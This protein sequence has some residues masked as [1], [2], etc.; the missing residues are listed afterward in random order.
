MLREMDTIITYFTVIMTM[1]RMI[2]MLYL[3]YINQPINTVSGLNHEVWQL[4]VKRHAI[5]E[6]FVK[7]TVSYAS[8]WS[9]QLSK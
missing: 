5:L 3:I 4:I 6:P 1:C 2:Y 7:H 9:I 8:F